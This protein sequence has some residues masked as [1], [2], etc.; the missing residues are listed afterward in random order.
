MSPYEIIAKKRDGGELTPEEIKFFV[1]GYTYGEIPDYQMAALLMAIFLRSM[2]ANEVINFTKTMINTGEK[3]DLSDI[4]GKKVDKHSTG[5]VGDKVSLVL[6]PLVAACGVY[7]PMISG[8]GLGHSGGTLDKLEAIPGFRT[9]LS[10]KQSKKVLEEV[11]FCMIG[12]TKEMVP[13]DKKLYALRDVTATVNSVPLISASI[14]SKKII[15][16]LDGLVLDVKTGV[17][18]FMQTLD[19]SLELARRLI[20]IGTGMGIRVV[21]IITNMDQP[22]GNAVGNGIETEEAINA[23]KGNG[24]DDLM[25]VTLALGEQM[26]ILGDAAKTESEAREKL[27]EALTSGN[28]LNKFK[29]LIEKQGGDISVIEHPE[30]LSKTKFELPLKSDAD[31]CIKKIDA[32]EVGLASVSMGAGRLTVDSKIDPAI[33]ILLKKKIG[34]EVKKDE[35]ILIV[36]ANSKELG[37]KCIERIRMKAIEI[38]SKDVNPPKL[39][40]HKVTSEEVIEL[41][42]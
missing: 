3:F 36:K 39:I 37:E 11:G 33:G 26:L 28:A 29:D 4:P 41:G 20:E 40:L 17:G 12:Q 10:I 13:A 1:Y 30:S 18:A 27:N 38:T 7:I 6:A 24:P 16:D 2:S 19:Q 31:G 14:M 34:D 15:E 42:K 32:L 9:D 5:G 35:E 25:E 21:G 22:L 23:L 8:R